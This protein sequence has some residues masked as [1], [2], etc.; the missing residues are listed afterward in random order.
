MGRLSGLWSLRKPQLKLYVPKRAGTYSFAQ[1]PILNRAS[2]T[3]IAWAGH[4]LSYYMWRSWDLKICLF[5]LTQASHCIGTRPGG[6][7]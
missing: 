3:A 7:E 1:I 6:L 4:R 5:S 2:V